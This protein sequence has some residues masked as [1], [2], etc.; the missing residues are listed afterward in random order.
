MAENNR[1]QR[2]NPITAPSNIGTVAPG[3]HV[4][5][6][7][8]NALTVETSNG[9]VQLDTGDSEEKAR[10]MLTRLREITDAPLHAIVYSHGHL[11]YNTAAETW[12]AHA[13]ERGEPRPRL[14]AHEN[15]VKRWLRFG[16]TTPLQQM[17]IE[18]QFRIPI[19]L[20][21]GPLA[22]TMP[23][24]TFTDAM[25]LGTEGSRIQLLWAPS[26]TDDTIVLWLPERKILYG[27]SAITPS[28]PNI[29]TPL[30]TLRDPIRWANTLD[31]LAALEPEIVVME[32]GRHLT[33]PQ[34]IQKILT[35]TSAALRWVHREV[36]DFIN[37]GY[38]VEEILHLIKYPAD[39]FDQPW[40]APTYGFADYIVRDIFRSETGWWD[41]NP[42]HLHPAHPDESSEAVLSAIT[43]R[44]A[45][46]QRA[47][48]LAAESKYQLALH[49]IDIIAKASSD[50]PD[51][52]Q[53]KKLKAEFCRKLAEQS[54]SFVSQSLYI[55]SANIIEKGAPKPT[56]IR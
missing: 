13:A 46:L 56:G 2:G 40:M 22:L 32:F 20:V 6:G 48:E 26:E 30:R 16:N 1:S 11:G 52:K 45:V 17:F 21:K 51:V 15:L 7:M 25:T 38:S 39:L 34:E 33:D 36:I 28:I 41:R 8:G 47:E 42:T 43:D 12:L 9:I 18:F 35:A 27:S 44:K 53:A 5:G 31:R 3:V 50:D 4:L 10:G 49:V 55:S 23:T 37:L 14:I 24:E 54:E 29:G 19:G